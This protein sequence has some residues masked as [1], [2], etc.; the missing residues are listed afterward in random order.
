[1]LNLCTTF[2]LLNCYFNE[3]SGIYL[4]FRIYALLAM[5]NNTSFQNFIRNVA[6]SMFMLSLI[7]SCLRSGNKIKPLKQL[8]ENAVAGKWI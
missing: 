8:N 2:C 3:Q 5:H 4:N 6:S 1:M 7:K